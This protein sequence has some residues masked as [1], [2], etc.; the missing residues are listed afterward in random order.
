MQRKTIRLVMLP[1]LV[2]LLA[3][4]GLIDE[5]LRPE[6]E[7][8]VTTES[9]PTWTPSATWTPS[10]TWTLTPTATHAPPANACNPRTVWPVYTVTA[11]DTLARIASLT[12]STVAELTQA[13][14]LIDANRIEVGQR[15]YVPQLSQARPDLLPPPEPETILTYQASINISSFVRADAG[16]YQLRIG[17]TIT[18]LWV[19]AP[20]PV[21]GVVFYTVNAAG[22]RTEIGR[23]IN[24][25]DGWSL[26]WTVPA[27]LNGDELIA[28][29]SGLGA[30]PFDQAI[31][32]PQY[33]YSVQ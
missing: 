6:P 14:C 4:C 28:V 23:D 17:E 19:D 5:A 33:V 24:R 27:G 1:V 16:N 3:A 2:V 22:M 11:G 8:I 31:S 32:A 21:G 20:E 10:P 12:G 7:P 13:N 9:S 26:V 29:G 15:L 25:Q 18:L 30:A